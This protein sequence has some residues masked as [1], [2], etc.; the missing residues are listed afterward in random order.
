VKRRTV[1]VRIHA[2]GVV[3]VM[4]LAAACTDS[5]IT[6][7]D[8]APVGGS[9]VLFASN[10]ADDNF[11]IYRIAG[12]GEDLRRL[13]VDRVN[14]D[15]APVVSH[16]G[17]RVAW[18][19][20]IVAA[21][22][23]VTSVEIWVMDVDGSNQHV[24]VKNGAENLN[25]SWAAG[26]SALVYESRAPGNSD[27]FRI[28][29]AGG[30][31]TNLTNNPFADQYPRVSPD[32]TKI[33]FQSN[34]DLNFDIY[35][36]NLDGSGVRNLTANP[37]DDRFASWTPDG[38][39]VVW[40]RFIDS[41]DVYLMNADGSNQH[42]VVATAFEETNPSVSPDGASVVYQTNRFPRSSLEIA[43]IDGAGAHALTGGPSRPA[44]SDVA[45]WWT[46]AAP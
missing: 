35:V 2:L 25:P 36:M 3:A 43:G 15:L 46:A 27:I 19:K 10:R 37:A 18:Q 34:R 7:T 11:E 12:T 21:D 5:N 20:E 17:K 40:S 9:V 24:V 42:P 14:N 16:D 1:A 41:F 22:G 4:M 23:S 13:T 39:R 6:G 8:H 33:L 32:G 44:I 38:T 30:A 45:P 29:L 28:S 26:D 31:A